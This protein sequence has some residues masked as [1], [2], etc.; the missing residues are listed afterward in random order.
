MYW[1]IAFMIMM[2]P[3]LIILCALAGELER[4]SDDASE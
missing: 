3:S 2:L 1:L 4:R